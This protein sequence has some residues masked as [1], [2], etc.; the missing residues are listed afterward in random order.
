MGRLD[1]MNTSISV[2][3]LGHRRERDKRITSHLGLTA[4]AFGADEIILSGEEDPSPLLTWNSVSNRFGGEFIC[5]YESKPLRLL[6]KTSKD[7]NTLIVHLTMY[8]EKIE[9]MMDK[10]PFDESILIVVGGTKVPGEVYGLA[11]YNISIG[12]QPHSEV[13]ALAIFLNNY[14]DNAALNNKFSGGEIKVVPTKRG[15]KILTLEEE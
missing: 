7:K 2:L 9:G 8:G 12:S 15:K 13:A 14:V 1:K 10:F 5:R 6:R 3:R 4:R 11:D